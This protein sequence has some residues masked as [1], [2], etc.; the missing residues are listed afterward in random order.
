MALYATVDA[1]GVLTGFYDST[2]HDAIPQGAVEL[3][4]AQYQLWVIAQSTLVWNGSDLVA[5]PTPAP[6]VLT[7][8]EQ[9][10]AALLAGCQVTSTATPA[11]DGT[12]AITPD[13]VS[14]IMATS[15]YIQVNGKFPAGQAQLAWP[16]LAGKP[17]VFAATDSFQGFATAIADYVAHLDLF[18]NG[19]LTELPA[20]PVALA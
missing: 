7:A 9:A 18:G 6:P 20:Q 13:A 1:N 17:H 14:K 10:L 8:A 16:D 15:L 12:Y 5:A 4:P 3:N 19:T 11:L 2:L